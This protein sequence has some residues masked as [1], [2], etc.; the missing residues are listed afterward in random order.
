MHRVFAGYLVTCFFW[1]ILVPTAG[2][3][4]E[5][6]P[7]DVLRQLEGEHRE[8]KG[9]VH[10]GSVMTILYPAYSLEVDE[11]YHAPLKELLEALKTPMRKDYRIVLKGYTDSSA[12][13]RDNLRLSLERAETLEKVLVQDPAMA[14]EAERI[15]VEGHGE[16][17]PVASNKTIEGRQRNRR[18]EVHICGDVGE[19]LRVVEQQKEKLPRTDLNHGDKKHGIWTGVSTPTGIGGR[20]EDSDAVLDPG[21]RLTAGIEETEESVPLS[22]LD[23]IRYSLEGNHDLRVVS[24]VP[25]QAAEDLADAESVYDPSL[26]AD[27]EYRRDPNLLTSVTDIVM[28]DHG[29]IQTGI[30]KPLKT[31]GSLSTLLEMGFEELDNAQ[32]GRVYKY[33]FGPTVEVRQ[34]LPKNL[35]SKKE[36]AAIKIANY[37]ADISEEEFRE[38]VIEIVTRVARAYWQLY[39]ARELVLINQQNFDMAEEVLR[40][41]AVRL[42]EGISKPFHVERA[43]SNAQARRSTLLK[44]E[45]RFRAVMDQVKLLLNW[46]NVTID[47]K[48]EVVPVERPRTLPI[49]VNEAEAVT[50]ALDN[51]PELEKARHRVHIRRVEEGLSSHERLPQLDLLARYSFSGYGKEFSTAA[52]DTSLN[53]E[54]AWVLGL[55]FEWPLG[56]RSAAA[57]HRKKAL[58]RQQ[59]TAAVERMRAQIEREVKRVLLAINLA[60]GDIE[61]TCLAKE[62][63][64]K[65]VQGEFARYDLE[66]TSN[67][68]LLRAQDLLAVTSRNYVRA[69]ADYN[70]ALAELARAQGILPDGVTIESGTLPAGM[71]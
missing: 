63:A 46:A 27:M 14:I 16:S 60:K 58:E 18:V 30:R 38:R 5:Q 19:A 41:E 4:V 13:E 3:E 12:L 70:T 54:N 65:V 42:A 59:A 34:P 35:G 50:V 31:G 2:G 9:V 29:R 22:L 11:R 55:N 32:S 48:V 21:R 28:E 47:S 69:L 56:N 51:R 36:Q 20:A 26:L 45:E 62:A 61:S 6:S 7:S 68:E 66:Q 15:E 10:L 71:R 23:A 43:R 44:S 64:E 24:Y 17:N 37:Q 8:S 25:K 1:V 53:D 39:L 57:R 67:E 40:R 49:E 52:E 33:S